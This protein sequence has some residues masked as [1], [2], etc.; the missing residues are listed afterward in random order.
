MFRVALGHPLDGIIGFAFLRDYV[1]EI[2]YSRRTLLLYAPA[3]YRYHGDGLRLRMERLR[4]VIQAKVVLPDGKER[5]TQLLIDTGSDTELLFLSSLYRQICSLAGGPKSPTDHICRTGWQLYLCHGM[6]AQ[7]PIRRQWFR[8]HSRVQCAIRWPGTDR[9]RR[10]GQ[11]S[12]GWTPWKYS[13]TARERDLRF[14]AS[15]VYS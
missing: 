14:V 10:H 4:P 9:S 3:H 1:A 6:A 11:N 8:L 15:A 2:N 7:H 13:S 5:W 12:S